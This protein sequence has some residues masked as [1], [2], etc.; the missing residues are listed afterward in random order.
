MYS[1]SFDNHTP[2][3]Y[4]FKIPVKIYFLYGNKE[5][6]DKHSSEHK[7]NQMVLLQTL[8]NGLKNAIIQ[9]WQILI[10]ETSLLLS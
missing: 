5:S 6:K 1:R 7:Y 10:T 9:Q 2:V 3:R 8:K 4:S